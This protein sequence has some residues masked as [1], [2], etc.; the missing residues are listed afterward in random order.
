MLKF[1]DL[2]ELDQKFVRFLAPVTP[3]Y[4]TGIYKPEILNELIVYWNKKWDRYESI[5]NQ[6]GQKGLLEERDALRSLILEQKQQ[7]KNVS[8]EIALERNGFTA[9]GVS[10][11]RITEAHRLRIESLN[12]ASRQLFEKQQMLESSL[13]LLENVINAWDERA[14]TERPE[15]LQ[16]AKDVAGRKGQIFSDASSSMSAD[17]YLNVS[18]SDSSKDNEQRAQADKPHTE[19]K[20]LQAS[21]EDPIQTIGA[22]V[23]A[24][25]ESAEHVDPD[26]DEREFKSSEVV[27]G[28]KQIWETVDR[29]RAKEI[30]YNEIYKKISFYQELYNLDT[31]SSFKS[32]QN[33]YYSQ[34]KRRKRKNPK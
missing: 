20:S 7:Q 10:D 14:D 16:R 29:L 27:K 2:S 13:M 15:F 26:P 34:H 12:R 31:Y 33:A 11:P 18:I 22:I 17:I 5:F 21:Q 28:S 3:K 25:E 4:A 8:D 6:R 24:N 30:S 32:F 9:V 19:I 23:K 1:E